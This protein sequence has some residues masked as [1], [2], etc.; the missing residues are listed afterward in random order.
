MKRNK[1]MSNT[2]SIVGEKVE[3]VEEFVHP[4][5]FTWTTDPVYKKG[6]S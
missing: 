5:E 1:V 6:Q 3:E 2:I 4:S